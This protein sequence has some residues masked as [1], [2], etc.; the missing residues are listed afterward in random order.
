M[1]PDLSLT[2][3]IRFDLFLPLK[4]CLFWTCA[5]GK[6]LLPTKSTSAIVGNTFSA[7]FVHAGVGGL[8]QWQNH[9][10]RA[11]TM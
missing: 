3:L 10:L 2:L 1:L 7:Y 8:S 9:I 4:I 6:T 5:F 11:L